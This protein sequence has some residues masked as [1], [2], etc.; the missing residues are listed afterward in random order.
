MLD[1]LDKN[2]I[3]LDS[4]IKEIIEEL[5]NEDI[6]LFMG[7]NGD[8]DEEIVCFLKIVMKNVIKIVDDMIKKIKEWVWYVVF[9]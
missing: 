3:K 8:I 5:K 9:I 6:F 2:D 1:I 7:K 4:I